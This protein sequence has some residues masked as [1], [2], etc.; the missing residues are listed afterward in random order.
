MIYKWDFNSNTYFQVPN[1]YTCVCVCR[2]VPQNANKKLSK[3]KVGGWGEKKHNLEI[4]IYN[5]NMP[6]LIRPTQYS[7]FVALRH[8][9]SMTRTNS[10]P[11]HITIGYISFQKIQAL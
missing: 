3:G 11:G 2:L 1:T 10:P 4:S 9:P 8:N 6:A 7:I 5:I